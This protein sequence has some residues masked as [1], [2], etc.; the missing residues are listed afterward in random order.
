MT[1]QLM[2][3]QVY[4]SATIVLNESIVRAAVIIYIEENGFTAEQVE[5]EMY[6]QIGRGFHWMP[7]LVSALKEYTHHRDIYPTLNDFYPEIAKTLGT[8]VV[9]EHKCI[10]EAL[11]R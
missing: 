8:Y 7:E 9:N 11:G 2:N 5:A 10:D 6:D 1:K 3:W 4:K